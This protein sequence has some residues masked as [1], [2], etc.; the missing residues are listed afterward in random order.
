[1][2]T[3]TEAASGGGRGGRCRDEMTYREAVNAALE[4]AIGEDPTVVLMGE[5]VD[6]DGGVFKTN[7]GPAREVPGERVFATPICENGF[8][9]V[10][11]GMSIT[12]MRPVVE[13][14]FADFMP[15]AGDAI[16][17]Q[18]PKY[19]YM[20]GGQFTRPGDGPRHRRAAAAGSGPSTAPPARAGTWPSPACASR[21]RARPRAAY[22][23][24]RA[25][26]RANDPVLFHEHKV[27]V[28]PQG[29]GPP[30][31]DRGDRQGRDRAG[32]HGR[33]HRRHPA[34][35]RVARSRRPTSWPRRAS[36]RRSST[37]AG[38]G[39]STWRP[40][41]HRS[42]KTGRLVIAEE[43]W[44]EAG[45]GAT[46]ISQLAQ[47]GTPFKAPPVAVSLPDDLLIPYSP[48]LEDEFLPSAER[49]ADGGPGQ[50]AADD[51]T[52]AGSGPVEH[53]GPAAT[54]LDRDVAAHRAH[55][56]DR[57]AGA[58]ARRFVG[59]RLLDDR[60]GRRSSRACTRRTGC[61]SEVYNGDTDAEQRSS[62]ASSTD[63]LA[64]RIIGRSATDPEGAWSAMEPSTNNILRDRGL[65]LQAIACLDTAIWD[66][67]AKAVGLPL[68]RLWG[69]VTDSLPDERHRRLLPPRPR[70]DP[71]RSWPATPSASRA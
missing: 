56:D 47:S 6:A 13:F 18:L 7:I 69:S 44:H 39:P 31:R 52:D 29:P 33:D 38:C 28:R 70:P 5:D 53:R 14:M 64:P 40:S 4:D 67:F 65:A 19:R 25:A 55:R 43:Q 49:I 45:W 37:C 34:D 42:R 22:E 24:L 59:Q 41:G 35:G 1:M 10:A 46:I 36:A 30:R 27:A 2:S 62:S 61:V 63:E 60:T 54:R 15:T 8:M 3:L 51:P 12:G 11:L 20:S 21:S 71:A 48:P 32:R 58:A 16:V 50:R 57:A 26:I 68:H 66:V 9:G 17:N 23:L